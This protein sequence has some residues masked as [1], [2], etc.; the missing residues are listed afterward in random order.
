[1]G[2]FEPLQKLNKKFLYYYLSSKVEENLKISAGAAQPNLST[3]Q[4]KNFKIPIPPLAEQKQIVALLDAAFAA[5]DQAKANLERNIANAKELF[6]SK[7]NEIF[8]QK[9]QGWEEK[10]LGEVCLIKPPKK[11]AKQK[12]KEDDEVSFVPMKCLQI[13]QMHFTS[14]ETRKLKK[15]YLGYVYFEEG[16]VV[17]AKITPC[18]ENGKLGIA[19]NLK[20]GVG[21]GSSEYVVYRCKE[22]LL[23]DYLYFFMNRDSFRNKGRS[24]MSGAVGHKR[25]Q[26]EFYENEL[27]SLPTVQEQKSICNNVFDIQVKLEE[28]ASICYQKL[29]H[30]EELKK[31]ILQKAFAGELS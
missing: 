25:I 6:Q 16:D 31:S 12:L 7:L 28:V 11:L 18:F 23:P 4:I 9:G 26:P 21:F 22:L 19:Y 13:N 14:K 2:K 3:N 30:L 24:L 29:A 8:S 5:I 27:I 10:K 15:A 20:N 1:V 17:L